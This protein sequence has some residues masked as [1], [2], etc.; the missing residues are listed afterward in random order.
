MPAIRRSKK[1]SKCNLGKCSLLK[2]E[3]NACG[4]RRD[5]LANVITVKFGGPVEI[6]GRYR[7]STLGG[8][9]MYMPLYQGQ[10]IY[11]LTTNKRLADIMVEMHL[12]SIH[13]DGFKNLDESGSEYS[14]VPLSGPMLLRFLLIQVCDESLS[15]KPFLSADQIFDNVDDSESEL[16]DGFTILGEIREY[17]ECKQCGS[18]DHIFRMC[19]EFSKENADNEVCIKSRESGENVT[20]NVGVFAF[21]MQITYMPVAMEVRKK[22]YGEGDPKRYDFGKDFDFTKGD[23]GHSIIVNSGLIEAASKD[24]VGRGG[25][26]DLKLMLNKL[27]EERKDE[28]KKESETTTS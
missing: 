11:G 9:Y 10:E 27:L 26:N 8:R 5:P 18:E 25:I 24:L 28:E 3:Y 19:F 16:L 6:D 22:M 20:F 21:V 23:A 13:G 15:R 7:H 14:L 2:D 4:V 17:I 12:S 1:I